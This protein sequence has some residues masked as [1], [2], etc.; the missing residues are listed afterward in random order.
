[1]GRIYE[2]CPNTGFPGVEERRESLK[3]FARGG[4][5]DMFFYPSETYPP[6]TLEVSK[7]YLGLLLAYFDQPGVREKHGV[8]V[9]DT[10]VKVTVEEALELR[11][12]TGGSLVDCKKTLEKHR[13]DMYEATL[14]M[15]SR[16]NA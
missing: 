16:G 9:P 14:E 6:G 15:R 3:L 8:T 11:E 4:T 5:D 10:E 7:E 12:R 2:D 13:G 1:M